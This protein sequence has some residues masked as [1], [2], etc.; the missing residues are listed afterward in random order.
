MGSFDEVSWNTV[1]CQETSNSIS[2]TL[3]PSSSLR[4]HLN[5]DSAKLAMWEIRRQAVF[6]GS[7]VLHLTLTHVTPML[8]VSLRG[9]GTCP[10]RYA[11][12]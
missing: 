1:K 9:T 5:V 8:T 10:A 11:N 7:L 3:S 6:L 2:H 12:S 4:G